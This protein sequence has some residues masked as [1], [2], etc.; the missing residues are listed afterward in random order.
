MLFRH[1]R[2]ISNLEWIIEG[3][4]E[5]LRSSDYTCGKCD[6]MKP[7]Y[8]KHQEFSRNIRTWIFKLMMQHVYQ[9]RRLHIPSTFS[10]CNSEQYF[11]IDVH[12]GC[13]IKPWTTEYLLN[14]EFYTHSSNCKNYFYKLENCAILKCKS[15]IILE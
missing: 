1:A 4:H 2:T 8:A 15:E 10:R 12:T 3:W 13:F 6:F 14:C 5:C 9:K 7:S 11:L